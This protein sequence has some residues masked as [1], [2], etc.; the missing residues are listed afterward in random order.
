MSVTASS[1][2][3]ERR[4]LSAKVT[5][6]M[7]LA[8]ETVFFG[9]LVIS[10]LY[11]RSGQTDWPYLQHS[12][13]RLIVPGLNSLV[14]VLSAWI[15]RRAQTAIWDGSTGGLNRNLWLAWLLG[16]LFIAGQVFEFQRSG[17]YPSDPAFGGVF[18]ALMGFHALHVLAGMLVLAL[19]G[20][21]S[22]LGDFNSQEHIA[23]DASSWFWYYVT[24]VWLVLFAVLY[25]V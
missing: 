5:L 3:P 25:L 2:Q 14:L 18:F 13:S 7:V 17:M 19:I 12:V 16:L 15:V 9:T 21:R 1:S 4:E 11:L 10:Y 24:A 22:R 6:A 20:L 23:V 8:S